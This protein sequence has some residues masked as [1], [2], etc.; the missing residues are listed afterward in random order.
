MVLSRVRLIRVRLVLVNLNPINDTYIGFKTLQ[1]PQKNLRKRSWER[2]GGKWDRLGHV[3]VRVTGGTGTGG[4][5]YWVGQDG[6]GT[7]ASSD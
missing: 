3:G 5:P 1:N 6:T 2:T 4:S 7:G